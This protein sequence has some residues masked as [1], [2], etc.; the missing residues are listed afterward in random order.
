MGHAYPTGGHI[1][2]ED[3]SGRRV[4]STDGRPVNLL[5]EATWQT[6]NVSVAF[7]D[8]VKGN[9]YGYAEEE[10]PIFGGTNIVTAVITTILPQEWGPGVSGGQN[11]PAQVLG[12][13][14]AG[15]YIDVR[16][17][18]SRTKAPSNF[19]DISLG[20]F[21]GGEVLNMVPAQQ[22]LLR[23]G[24]CLCES[25]YIWRRLFDVGLSGNQIVLNRYQ[26][27]WNSGADT[28]PWANGNNPQIRSRWT[29][30][31]P[32]GAN[33]AHPAYLERSRRAYYS[34]PQQYRGGSNAL[35]LSD[36]SDYSAT[37]GGT[38]LIRPGY[39]APA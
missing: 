35:S 5:P 7:P 16:A 11:L 8:F 12:T 34:L 33:R 30:G 13:V 14:A 26:S 31:G 39:L 9:A 19:I 4:W 37:W 36:T 22:S 17:T 20:G 2:F 29:Y 18:L 25:T 28:M 6:I 10:D 24:S 38:L 23:G 3:D 1:R 15:N 27:V 21:S 32:S